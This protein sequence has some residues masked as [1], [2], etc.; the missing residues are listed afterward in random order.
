MQRGSDRLFEILVSSSECRLEL[1]MVFQAGSVV[2]GGG[3]LGK[4]VAFINENSRFESILPTRHLSIHIF[5]T[6]MS[7]TLL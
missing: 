2:G 1:E 3:P 7:N 5:T 6:L 4:V